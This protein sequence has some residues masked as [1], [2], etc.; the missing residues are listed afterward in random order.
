LTPWRT[1][2]DALVDLALR[3]PQTHAVIENSAD[4]LA[5]LTD[6]W[7]GALENFDEFFGERQVHYTL[8]FVWKT[9]ISNAQCLQVDVVEVYAADVL[10]PWDAACDG[11]V[12]AELERLHAWLTD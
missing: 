9:M 10:S 3:N 11:G 5:A 6:T 4:L 2:L 12:R 1:F 7:K 8:S